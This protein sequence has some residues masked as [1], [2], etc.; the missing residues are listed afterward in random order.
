MPSE[1]Q[2]RSLVI[3]AG[4]RVVRVSG[5]AGHERTRT[6]TRTRTWTRK[7]QYGKG[8]HFCMCRS[9]RAVQHPVVRGQLRW[10][11]VQDPLLYDV[12]LGTCR[13][14]NCML[15]TFSC[16]DPFTKTEL[17]RSFCLS[18]YGCALWSMSATQFHSL[19]VTFNK[20]YTRSGPSLETVTQPS[21]WVTWPP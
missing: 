7:R 4:Y 20:F 6:R 2:P 15:H 18:L 12:C 13:K 14:A 16:C 21:C 11:Y 19:E 5:K 3:H 17:F 9:V 1:L 10:V 8:R